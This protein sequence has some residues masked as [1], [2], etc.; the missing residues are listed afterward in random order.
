MIIKN[1]TGHTVNI[2]TNDGTV[3]IPGPIEDKLTVNNK[4]VSAGRLFAE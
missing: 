3:S 2:L 4:A 1:L